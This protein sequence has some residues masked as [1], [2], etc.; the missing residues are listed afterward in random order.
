MEIGGKRKKIPEYVSKIASHA[1][2]A[3]NQNN[4]R[5]NGIAPIKRWLVAINFV[6]CELLTYAKPDDA[7]C[8][9]V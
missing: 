2:V 6:A 8:N 5:F 4:G 1:S 3:R 9:D 7:T